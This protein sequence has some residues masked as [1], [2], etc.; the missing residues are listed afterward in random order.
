[1]IGDRAIRGQVP[2]VYLIALPAIVLFETAM[3]GVAFTAL[4]VGIQKVIVDALR[5][6]F[7]LY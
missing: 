4:G 2:R 3:L 1:M 7:A 6:A 5:P